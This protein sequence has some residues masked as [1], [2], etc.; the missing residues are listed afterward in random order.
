MTVEI[1]WKVTYENATPEHHI[2]IF[3]FPRLEIWYSTAHL[4]WWIQKEILITA[5][6][7]V[8]GKVLKIL[9]NLFCAFSPLKE[10]F[11]IPLPAQMWVDR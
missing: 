8:F 10:I 3:S 5:R 7:G 4:G 9:N 2:L 6:Y 1:T 11:I